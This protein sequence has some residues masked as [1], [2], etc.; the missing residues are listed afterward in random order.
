M[1]AWNVVCLADT[2]VVRRDTCYDTDAQ[3]LA[4]VLLDIVTRFPSES[5]GF[6]CARPATVPG[7]LR[8]RGSRVELLRLRFV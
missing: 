3:N 5:M 7:A 1:V 6:T 8:V 4:Y 2:A